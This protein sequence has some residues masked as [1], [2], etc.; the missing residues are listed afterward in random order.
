MQVARNNRETDR[1]K[2]VENRGFESG[3]IVKRRKINR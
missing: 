3:K 2:K 1:Y